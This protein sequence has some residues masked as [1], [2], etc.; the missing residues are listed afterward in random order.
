MTLESKK[1][2]KT[3]QKLLIFFLLLVLI[4]IDYPIIDKAL[5]GFTEDY[6]MGAVERIIDGDTIVVNGSNVRLLGINTPEKGEKYYEEAKNFLESEML[7]KVVKLEKTQEDKDL[8]GR[9]L[10]YVISE[11]KNI[12]KK[13]VEQGFANPYFPS[14]RDKHYAEIWNAWS[15]CIKSNHGLCEKSANYCARCVRIR[16]L[17]QDKDEIILENTCRFYCSLK[18]WTL[19]DEGRKKFIFPDF[20]LEREVLIKV[21]NGTNAKNVLFWEGKNYVLTRIGDSVF[22]RD[23]ENMLVDWKSY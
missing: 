3:K 15:E 22:L 6:E 19:K 10:R 17:D 16:E 8:Y 1:R 14:S 23:N 12:N 2:I 13:I 21:G 18:R 7:D 5:K 20:V 4:A 9:K 11:N